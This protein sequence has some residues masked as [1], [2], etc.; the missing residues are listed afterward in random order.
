MIKTLIFIVML[1]SYSHA[2]VNSYQ[3]AFE[4][5]ECNGDSGFATVMIENIDKIKTASCLYEGKKLKTL[6]V[7]RSGTYATY[8]LTYDEAKSVMQDVKLYN[9]MRLKMMGNAN[10]LIIDK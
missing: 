10:T 1:F 2:G 8:T 6:L 9:R 7:R 4:T 5:T 3:V